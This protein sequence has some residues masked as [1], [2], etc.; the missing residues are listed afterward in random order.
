MAN[1]K[2]NYGTIPFPETCLN[3][4]GNEITL[5]VLL[6]VYNLTCVRKLVVICHGELPHHCQ[7]CKPG[8]FLKYLL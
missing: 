8:F 1:L 2:E 5:R 7:E 4:E 6:P 3:P